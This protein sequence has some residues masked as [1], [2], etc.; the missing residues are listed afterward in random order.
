MDDVTL[1][2]SLAAAGYMASPESTWSKDPRECFVIQ[3]AL[4][5]QEIERR[6]IVAESLFGLACFRT[7]ILMTMAR[8]AILLLKQHDLKRQVE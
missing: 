5:E 6:A 4:V 2:Q 3:L 7:E 8:A 1:A